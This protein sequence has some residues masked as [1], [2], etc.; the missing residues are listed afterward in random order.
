MSKNV[1][2]NMYYCVN[3]LLTKTALEHVHLEDEFDQ[4]LHIAGQLTRFPPHTFPYHHSAFPSWSLASIDFN[5]AALN[6]FFQC[7]E[8][9]RSLDKCCDYVPPTDAQRHWGWMEEWA[10]L[11][12]GLLRDDWRVCRKTTSPFDWQWFCT[13][14]SRCRWRYSSS[15]P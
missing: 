1:W 13:I 4:N 15:V 7:F 11:D 8:T 12:S 10:G 2:S 3:I 5:G 6:V 9:R 14:K